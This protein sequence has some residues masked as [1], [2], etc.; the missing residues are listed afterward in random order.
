[1]EKKDWGR[2]VWYLFHTLAHKLKPEYSGETD[3]LFNHINSICSNL[4]CPDCQEHAMKTL[5]IANRRVITSSKEALINFLHTF[6]NLIN[7]RTKKAE[8][9]KEAL[10]DMY[11]R[12]NTQNVISHFI[13]IMSSNTNNDK[14]MMNSFRRQNYMKSFITY[15]STNG[16]KY[17]P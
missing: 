8:F 4:P 1:M 12:A 11:A 16:Y 14:L 3:A 2:A 5:A 7:K 10:N 9:S 6:H 13:K 15:I 17:N